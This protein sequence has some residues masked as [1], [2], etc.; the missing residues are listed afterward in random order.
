MQ[1]NCSVSE[2]INHIEVTLLPESVKSKQQE[3]KGSVLTEDNV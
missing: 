3:F 2:A 1:R